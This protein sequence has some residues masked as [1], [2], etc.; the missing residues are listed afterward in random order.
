MK[1]LGDWEELAALDETLIGGT[2]ESPEASDLIN[3]RGVLTERIAQGAK[4]LEEL[5]ELA[6]RN[7]RLTEWLLHWRRIALI[8]AAALERHLLYLQSAGEPLEEPGRVEV[9]G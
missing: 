3:R 6:A 5:D 9:C 2:A 1:V 7:R 4:S 8:E